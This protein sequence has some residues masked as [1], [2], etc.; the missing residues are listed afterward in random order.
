MDYEPAQRF[1]KGNL[2]CPC[3]MLIAKKEVLNDLCEWLFPILFAVAEHGG[4]KEDSYLNR[5]PRFISERLISYFFEKNRE[6]YKVVFADKGFV[7]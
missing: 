2:Y 1:F 7:Q 5:Y 6:K 4:E 3:N